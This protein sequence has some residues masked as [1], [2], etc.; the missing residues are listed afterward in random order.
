[1]ADY[2]DKNTSAAIGGDNNGSGSRRGMPRLLA[3]LSPGRPLVPLPGNNEEEA[4]NPG[5]ID[6]TAPLNFD[7]DDNDGDEDDGNN[8]NGIGA[9]GGEPCGTNK[10]EQEEEMGEAGGEGWERLSKK[11]KSEMNEVELFAHFEAQLRG[12]INERPCF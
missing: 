10:E 7:N 6:Y 5:A 9:G 12:G 11:R 1:M 4:I 2:L 3:R 8:N